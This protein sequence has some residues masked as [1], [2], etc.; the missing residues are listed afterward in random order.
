VEKRYRDGQFRNYGRVLG[1]TFTNKGKSFEAFLFRGVSGNA[2][3][4]NSKGESLRK[5][6]LKAPLAFTRITSGY[7]KARRHPI[8]HDVRPHEGLDYA[9]PTGTPIKAVGDGVISRKGW[10]GG[11]GNTIAIRHG[12]SLESQYGHMSGYARGMA[13]GVRVRQGQ[14]IGFVG[15]TGWATGPHL[16]FRLKQHD[17]FINPAKAINPREE[18]IAPGRM[19][20][21]EERKIQIRNF[22]SGATPLYLYN[23]DAFQ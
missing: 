15:M 19:K 9:A 18:S 21:F 22:V 5:T 2:S 6:L 20:A 11:Y 17:R 4:Y 16:D 3:H 12:A 8:F 1:A 14:V 7:S 13:V 10:Q 23:L